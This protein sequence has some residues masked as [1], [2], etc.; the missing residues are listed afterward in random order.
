MKRLFLILAL[1][2]GLTACTRTPNLTPQAQVAYSADQIVLRINELQ[3]AAI[4]ANSNGGLSR[5]TTRLIVTFCVNADRTAK[6]APLGWEKTLGTAWVVLK[7]E[8]PTPMPPILASVVAAVDA[9]LTDQGLDRPK[10]VV[11]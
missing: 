1:S 10:G 6:D 2:F 7:T 9:V 3:N 8:I 4:A 11:R 5:D